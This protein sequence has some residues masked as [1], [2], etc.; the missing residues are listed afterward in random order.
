MPGIAVP[1]PITM[2]NTNSSILQNQAG[3]LVSVQ[4]QAGILVSAG[5]AL[6]MQ[7]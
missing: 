4:N 1:V 6:G 5:A 2:I 7:N 3:I